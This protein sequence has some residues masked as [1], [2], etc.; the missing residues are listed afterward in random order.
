MNTEYF[1]SFADLYFF[2]Q[3]HDVT[4]R[5]VG[6]TSRTGYKLVFEEVAA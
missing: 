5:G 3:S 2:V 6:F 4:V 1:E